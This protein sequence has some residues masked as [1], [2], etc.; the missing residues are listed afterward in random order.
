MSR[1]DDLRHDINELI[2]AA[3]RDMSN[4]NDTLLKLSDTLDQKFQDIEDDIDILH[5]AF[6]QLSVKVGLDAAFWENVRATHDANV[7]RRKTEQANTNGN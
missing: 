7:I 4:V 3:T 1:L 6:A 2:N 5:I